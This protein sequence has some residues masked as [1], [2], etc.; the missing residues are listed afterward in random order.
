MRNPFLK[1]VIVL[2]NGGIGCKVPLAKTTGSSKGLYHYICPYSMTSYFQHIIYH[3]TRSSLSPAISIGKQSITYSELIGSAAQV[4]QQ[5]QV[6][7]QNIGL[8]TDNNL[9]MYIS[10]LAIWIS[11]NAYVP[12]NHKFPVDR[13]MKIIDESEI[14]IILSS[15]PSQSTLSDIQDKHWI[16][17]Q[18]NR[19]LSI[20]IPN[21]TFSQKAYTLFTSGSTGAPKGIPITHGNLEALMIDLLERYPLNANHKVLQAFELSFD[22]SIACVLIALTQG[23]HLVVADLNGITAINAFKAIHESQVDF[24]VLPPS[25]LF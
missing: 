20:D 14:E 10:L 11:G 3:A 13:L 22:V 12:L 2:H 23:A 15:D 7:N 1:W 25:A 16:V 6:K 17:P 9:D 4:A 21:I 18:Y 24:V 5:I 8:Y 19:S